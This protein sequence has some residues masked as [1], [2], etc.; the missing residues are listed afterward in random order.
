MRD[1]LYLKITSKKQAFNIWLEL[2][3]F[4]GSGR[5]MG[6][7]FKMFGGDKSIHYQEWCREQRIHKSLTT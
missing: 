1:N 3:N 6:D 4:E 7:L 2:N 5:I